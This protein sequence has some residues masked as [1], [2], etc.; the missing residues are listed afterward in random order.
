[1]P[2]RPPHE[3]LDDHVR[4]RAEGDL[5]TDLARNYAPDIALLCQ[6]GH[7]LWSAGP[8]RCRVRDGADLCVI[9]DGRIAIQFISY[10]LKPGDDSAQE[11]SMTIRAAGA[12][13]GP[14]WVSGD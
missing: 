5:E 14:D 8:D 7:L 12:S 3:V 11:R 10:R 4:L 2:E 13:G 9:R 1:M 6:Y